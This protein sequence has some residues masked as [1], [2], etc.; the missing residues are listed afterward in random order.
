M[1]KSRPLRSA[2]VPAFLLACL[3]LGGSTRAEWPNMALQLAAIAILAWA[4]LASP[5]AQSG[6]PGQTLVRLALA[7]MALVALQLVPLPPSLW[8]ALPGRE[9]IAR[10]YGLLGEPLPWLPLSLAPYDTMTSERPQWR[11]RG[12]ARCRQDRHPGRGNGDHRRRAWT[13]SFAGR[14]RVG[15][16]G[17]CGE[18]ADAGQ[19][20]PTTRAVG[21]WRG[22]IARARRRARH[23]RQPAWQQPHR[24]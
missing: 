16:P 22:R 21:P 20:V 13:Q 4:A 9:F 11:A 6:L 7:M 8:T 5:R 2:I 17:R 3:L 1:T 12:P 15:D 19:P 14:D 10:G 24:S 23:V 18:P